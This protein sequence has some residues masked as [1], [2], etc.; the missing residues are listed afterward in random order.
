MD[1]NCRRSATKDRRDAT[2]VTVDRFHGW[3]S[4]RL[5][6]WFAPDTIAK[7]ERPDASEENRVVLRAT[8]IQ[9]YLS[10]I[11]D[12]ELSRTARTEVCLALPLDVQS[13]VVM[14]RLTLSWLRR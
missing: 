7:G 4:S 3:Q 11:G 2:L 14:T 1:L 6:C 12:L 9:T 5:G 10:V 8:R 13:D